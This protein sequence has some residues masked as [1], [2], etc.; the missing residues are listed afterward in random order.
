[1][2]RLYSFA[3][4]S[5][6]DMPPISSGMVAVSA[7]LLTTSFTTVLAP[8]FV[9]ALGVWLMIS[10]SSYSS[11]NSYSVL[12]MQYVRYSVLPVTSCTCLPVK[13]GSV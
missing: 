9:P 12:N 2:P 10:P 5:P 1:M 4:M 13:L 6:S 8:I 3:L 11:L 7:P